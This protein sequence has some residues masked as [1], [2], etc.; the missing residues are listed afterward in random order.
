M[1]AASRTAF[2][3]IGIV[4]TI[5][6]RRLQ[7]ADASFFDFFSIGLIPLL[8]SRNWPYF[9]QLC[10]SYLCHSFGSISSTANHETAIMLVKSCSKAEKECVL[11]ARGKAGRARGP[12]KR[13]QGGE[14]D[15]LG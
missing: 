13:Q 12:F 9:L 1:M 7:A 10:Y 4:H 5:C 11:S 8:A 2:G 15:R 3:E 6:G 14:V